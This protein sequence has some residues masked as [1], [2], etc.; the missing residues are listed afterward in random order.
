MRCPVCGGPT[1]NGLCPADPFLARRACT[2]L[3]SGVKG[4]MEHKKLSQ[5]I[6]PLGALL[7]I[8]WIAVLV[9]L[10]GVNNRAYEKARAKE[11]AQIEKHER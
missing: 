5:Q 3:P 1:I 11:R 9:W 8:V 10:A 2:V 6:S 4:G 7:V